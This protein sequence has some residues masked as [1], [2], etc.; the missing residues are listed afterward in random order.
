MEKPLIRELKIHNKLYD[1]NVVNF[2]GF[3]DDD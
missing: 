3:F 1:M 2:Y